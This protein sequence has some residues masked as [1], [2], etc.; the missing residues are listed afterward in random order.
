[1]NKLCLIVF[2]DLPLILLILY[3]DTCCGKVC[4]GASKLCIVM[5]HKQLS[6]KPKRVCY[7]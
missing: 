4:Y 6:W 1:M 5:G 2:F 7:G 3:F